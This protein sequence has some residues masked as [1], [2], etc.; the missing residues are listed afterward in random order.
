MSEEDRKRRRYCAVINGENVYRYAHTQAQAKSLF[1]RYAFSKGST[2]KITDFSV[3]DDKVQDKY[4]RI[5]FG[6]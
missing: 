5:S 4:N 1:R 2:S 3:E 6:F